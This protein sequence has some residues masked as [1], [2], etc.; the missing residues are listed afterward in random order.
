MRSFYLHLDDIEL[1]LKLKHPVAIRKP[2]ILKPVSLDA[3]DPN[4][5]NLLKLYE[6]DCKIYEYL[7]KSE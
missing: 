7:R 2:P 3:A 1:Q 6:L 5:Y 4:F